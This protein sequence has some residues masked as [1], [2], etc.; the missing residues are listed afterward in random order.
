M[1]TKLIMT[2]AWTDARAAAKK[3]GG[4]ASEFFAA[5]L[6]NVWALIKAIKEQNA[7][8]TE[9]A[10]L[11][12]S[13]KIC[14]LDKRCK[15]WAKVIQADAALPMP[16][17]VSEIGAYAIKQNFARIGDEELFQGEFLIECEQVHHAKN[18]GY[19]YWISWVGADGKRVCIKNPGSEIKA[20]LKDAGMEAAL[21]KGAGSLA[22]CIRLA[23][24]VRAG[25]YI[26]K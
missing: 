12:L 2:K 16:S 25:L 10:I 20:Q 9:S 4:R 15:Y 5:C 18:R 19:D 3:F 17:E 26:H 13:I 23:H 14:P 8:T 11:S 6:R 22:A 21:L 7:M 24:G 1:N